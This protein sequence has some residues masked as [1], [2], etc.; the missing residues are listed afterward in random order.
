MKQKSNKS[1]KPSFKKR[2][3]QHHIVN[4]GILTPMI[5]FL[6][7]SHRLVIEVGAGGGVLTEL[8]LEARA[9]V[10]AIEYDLE[11]AIY[12]RKK[13][14][15]R[16]LKIVTADFLCLDISSLPPFVV[17][18]NLP[19]NIASQ[20]ILKTLRSPN[21][22]RAAFMVQKEVAYRLIAKQGDSNRSA[23]SVITELYSEVRILK[24]VKRTSFIP[25]PKVDSAIVGFKKKQNTLHHK[26]QLEDLIFSFFRYKR[27]KIAKIA[28]TL[29]Y[30][31]LSLPHG[32]SN[33]RPHQLSLNDWIKI[34][35][36]I[37][38]H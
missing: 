5:D 27:K 32:V 9:D 26:K 19:F 23:F 18:G 3:G 34:S 10:I 6:S 31:N 33:L 29:G 38:S 22:E 1:S 35:D 36:I 20:I 2:L 8:L 37:N 15:N 30:H 4:K 13:I 7:P 25:P 21:V 11:W 14:T 17:C 12:L 24:H 16:S 28:K